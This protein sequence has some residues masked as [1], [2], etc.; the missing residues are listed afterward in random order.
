MG[1]TRDAG[2]HDLGSVARKF[3]PFEPFASTRRRPQAGLVNGNDRANGVS[4][5][6]NRGDGS[7]QAKLDDRIGGYESAKIGDLNGD[8]K[9]DLA[10]LNSGLANAVSVVLNTRGPLHGAKRSGTEVADR[11]ANARARQ[12]PRRQD[13]PRLLEDGQE[14]P[15][16]LAE[17]EVRRGAARRAARSTSRQPRAQALGE[18]CAGFDPPFPSLAQRKARNAARRVTAPARLCP[19]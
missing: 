2:A 19:R 12:L 8:G 18:P 3:A 9:P 17:A 7:F 11:E 5:L 15:R 10:A 1:R 4:V 14:E 13:Q 6:L 16:D